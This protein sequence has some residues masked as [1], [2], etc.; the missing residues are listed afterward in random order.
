MTK[1]I[2]FSTIL[3][4]T[5]FGAVMPAQASSYYQGVAS[6]ELI[7]AVSSGTSL[8]STIIDSSTS[9][10]IVIDAGANGVCT[11]NNGFGMGLC[12]H[13]EFD[14]TIKN[15][16]TET[17][18]VYYCMQTV[19]E[20]TGSFARLNNTGNID[21]A[22][23]SAT[24]FYQCGQG[25]DMVADQELTVNMRSDPWPGGGF[26][27]ILTP[28]GTQIIFTTRLV[29]AF[30]PIDTCSDQFT[31]LTTDTYEIDPT[32]ET[33]LGPAGSPADDQIYTTV[34]DQI[35]KITT[36]GGPWNDGTTDRGKETSVSW[37]GST[38]TPLVEMMPTCF[39]AAGAYLKAESTT[40]YIR[41]DD[42]AG[43]FADNTNNPDPVTYTI[44]LVAAPIS[45]CSSQFTYD[46]Q[47]DWVAS[48]VVQG[49]D[50]D[51]LLASETLTVGE[52]YA[53]A[54]VPPS[55]WQDE[56]VPPDLT[57]MDY[58]NGGS[59]FT[60]FGIP[61][62]PLAGASGSALCQSDDGLITY[63]QAKNEN[64]YLRVSNVEN[65]FTANTGQLD[66][67][68]YHAAFTRTSETCETLFAT[69][70]LIDSGT[71]DAQAE[72][73][74]SFAFMVGGT[75]IGSLDYG[76]EAGAWYMLD[77]TGGPWQWQ[78]G[79]HSASG[80][81]YDM[82]VSEDGSTWTPL[83]DWTRPT[84]NVM[85]D[86]VGHRRVIF[87][88]P[89]S[90]ALEW[91]L[92]VDDSSIWFNNSGTMGWNLYGVKKLEYIPQN[93]TCDYE[94]NNAVQIDSGVVY[95]DNASG[96]TLD[97]M[98]SG[99]LYALLI[100]GTGYGWQESTGGETLYS[101][102]LSNNNGTTYFNMPDDYPGVLC[103]Q[104]VNGNDLLV[105]LQPGANYRYRLRVNST[106]FDNNT[107]SMGYVVYN[108]TAGQS[109]VPTCLNGWYGEEVLNGFDWIDVRNQEGE[110]IAADTAR[111]EEFN[112][113][114]AGRTY[115]ITTP[116]GQ[117][118]WWS[119]ESANTKRWDVAVTND[120]GTN[121]EGVALSGN[122]MIDCAQYNEVSHEWQIR[123]TVQEGEIWKIRV[124]DDAGAFDNNAGNMAYK[125]Q[126]MCDHPACTPSI[127]NDSTTG[128]IPAISIQGGGD[129]CTL[130]IV[131]PGSLSA[132]EILDV[133]N[134]IGSWVQY[135]NLSVLRYM[136][137]CPSH[138]NT[139]FTF[140]N[141][142]YEKEPL[143]TVK[144]WMD[145]L[146]EIKRQIQSYNWGDGSWQDTS[147]F[148]MHSASQ[149]QTMINEHILPTSSRARDP[150]G[151]GSIVSLS[152]SGGALPDAYYSCSSAFTEFLPS[153][154]RSGVCFASAWMIETSASFWIQIV[155][156]ISALFL[157]IG[158][159]KGALQDLIYMMTGVRPWTK[160]GAN[161]SVD[162]LSAYL[163]RRDREDDIASELGGRFGG[164][165]R[166]NSDGSYSRR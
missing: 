154:L 152:T 109:L 106:T 24:P 20:N 139:L 1:K 149:V 86:A 156:D 125:L 27:P 165:Y 111:Y 147:I 63:V 30:A 56:G 6:I 69:Q 142:F 87:Q 11:D 162:K 124:N 78:G 140:L 136:A 45:D 118:P 8:T 21:L 26:G 80:I 121:W 82:A 53:V 35:Y 89:D 93:N 103:S 126:T 144:E 112:G 79:G 32:I 52:W 29:I 39:S 36:D 55:A 33:P 137:W 48:V 2:L 138:T 46:E 155:L 19:V 128:G 110:L 166:R 95:A 114:I 43:N 49:N 130:P 5:L 54:V 58:F 107:G 62:I 74:A 17:Q 75:D 28:T 83:A 101:T 159:L 135:I 22:T 44:S 13:Q 14:V 132:G 98:Q 25:D 148:D 122:T 90:G 116:A 108:A 66:V 129:V 64:L 38:W 40:F 70:S 119:A 133:G 7:E 117:G 141:K 160:S 163:E 94:Y 72:N 120:G 127:P 88:M 10:M 47:N 158:M 51:G 23:W 161:A 31:E 115:L 57:T 91:K 145:N 34:I 131:R 71:V 105:F 146:R 85:L 104:T 81:L 84:C 134:Y 15:T 61:Y 37:D 16:S 100:A 92:R 76:L 65:D 102:E 164:S 3:F 77:T 60:L 9:Q 67:N 50:E 4:L 99:N 113:L 68:I 41:V 143:A 12:P 96:V 153:R 42:T 59:E 157:L 18:H 73:G 123:V 151:G 150:W 97:N